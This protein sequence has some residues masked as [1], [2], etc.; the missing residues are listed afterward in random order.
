MNNQMVYNEELYRGKRINCSWTKKILMLLIRQPVV[1]GQF[2]NLNPNMLKRQID[3]CFKHRIGPKRMEKRGMAAAVVPHA[4]FDYSGPIAAW[5]YSKMEQANYIIIG[6]NHSG[7]GSQFAIM[8]S[9][10]WKTPLGELLIHEEMANR[11]LERCRLLEYD[12][13]AHQNEHS[14]EVQLPF[15]QYRFGNDFK[16]IPISVLN[17]FVDDIL[18]D[19]CKKIGK[20][21]AE[22]I[23]KS[24]EKWIVIAT[25]DFSHYISHQ[26][27]NKVDKVCIKSI[28]K[29]NE[30]DFFSKINEKHASICG[31]GAI[32]IVISAAKELGAKKAELLKYA[33]SG[34]ITGELGSVVGYASII[35]Y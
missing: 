25:S 8:K 23:K 22:V 5:I 2:Y 3:A 17:E 1:A 27:A 9:G 7:L 10:L 24:K 33:T 12:V 6:P 21:I 15:L 16:F 32:A 19:A 26:T 31:F 20:D 11:L 29:L 13:L 30:D 35:I 28:L 4:G 34:D 14:V 18:L